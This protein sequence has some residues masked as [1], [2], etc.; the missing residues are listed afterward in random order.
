MSWLQ[1]Q[2]HGV[3]ANSSPTKPRSQALTPEQEREPGNIG[4]VKPWTSGNVI[5]RMTREDTS[6]PEVIFM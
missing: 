6:L 3:N 1:S 4:G 5:V 2:S